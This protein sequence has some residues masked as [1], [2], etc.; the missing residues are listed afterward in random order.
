MDDAG[1]GSVRDSFRDFA[2]RQAAGVSPLYAVLA[3]NAANDDEVL[4]T[5]A[6]L[7]S[8]QPRPEALLAAAHRLLTAEPWLPLAG[9]YP[10]LG[11]TSGPDG[12]TWPLF[13]EFV[14]ARAERIGALAASRPVRHNEITRSALLYPALSVLASETGRKLGLVHL[15]AEAGLLL[16]VNHYHH[17]YQGAEVGELSAGPAAARVRLRCALE[18]AP[19]ARFPTLPRTLPLAATIGVDSR[20]PDLDDDEDVAWLE[21][22]V[23]ADQPDWLAKMTLGF[24]AQ[25]KNPPEMVSSDPVAGIAAAINRVPP[26]AV[27]VVLTSDPWWA[28]PATAT[29]HLTALATE[30]ATLGRQRP[31]WWLSHDPVQAG[32]LTVIDSAEGA[33]AARAAGQGHLLGLTRWSEGRPEAR[34]LA[35]TDRGGRRMRWLAA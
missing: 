11:G 6:G 3:E 27:P 21:A 22:C 33:G 25:R 17:R 1:L 15:G 16:G 26:D 12:S 10:D 28:E 23:W 4:R 18:L 8:E 30:L 5:V 19:G 13:R 7:P 24:A 35:A 32:L 9:Y 31:L 20:P 34:V 14:L 29:V 2:H